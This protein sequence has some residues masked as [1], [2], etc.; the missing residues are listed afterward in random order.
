V[1]LGVG[2]GVRVALPLALP[3]AL[4]DALPLVCMHGFAWGLG[5]YYTDRLFEDLERLEGEAGIHETV[6]GSFG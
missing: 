3:D 4:P 2:V 1:L 5:A 6:C